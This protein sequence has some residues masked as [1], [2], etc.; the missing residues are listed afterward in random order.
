MR[1]TAFARGRIAIVDRVDGV[2]A[3]MRILEEFRES[4][5]GGG[6]HAVQETLPWHIIDMLKRPAVDRSAISVWVAEI[7]DAQIGPLSVP[8]LRLRVAELEG[9]CGLPPDERTVEAVLARADDR[10]WGAYVDRLMAE[11]CPV[12][13]LIPITTA[14]KAAEEANHAHARS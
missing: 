9:A 4:R 13:I 3:A 10:A 1:S 8:Y 12:E 14:A 7:L 5:C 2:V 11:A 6:G